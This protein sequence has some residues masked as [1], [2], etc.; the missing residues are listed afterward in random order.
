MESVF[1]TIVMFGCTHEKTNELK[2]ALLEKETSKVFQ[3]SKVDEIGQILD[4]SNRTAILVD[5]VNA[6]LRLLSFN[7]RAKNRYFRMY[8]LDWDATVDRNT[9]GSLGSRGVSTIRASE[10]APVIER[11]EIYLNGKVSILHKQDLIE[12]KMDEKGFIG[13]AFFTMIEMAPS[14]G[15]LLIS[16]HERENDVNELIGINWDML[17]SDVI[18]NASTYLKPQETTLENKSYC[19]IIYPH[20]INGQ[21]T[22]MSI[23]HLAIDPKFQEN[24][25]RVMIFLQS[26]K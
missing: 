21:L 3:S 14:K 5:N 11:M 10:L 13:K 4:M 24:H 15:R 8:I 7:M 1:K 2:L 20:R 16:S 6:A 18:E 26:M 19:E 12:T 23:V 22:K 17:L 9:V 25:Q